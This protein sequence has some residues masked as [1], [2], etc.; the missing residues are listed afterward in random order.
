[1]N[2]SLRC[3]LS[4]NIKKRNLSEGSKRSNSAQKLNVLNNSKISKHSDYNNFE[5][6]N[7]TDDDESK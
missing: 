5:N 7:T 3:N 6:E 2:K 1:M 4:S